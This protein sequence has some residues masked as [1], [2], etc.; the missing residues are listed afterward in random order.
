MDSRTK[1]TKAWP[2]EP[3]K[4]DSSARS[5]I[6]TAAEELFAELGFDAA[7]LRQIAIKARVPVALVSYHFKDKLGLYRAVF[8]AR[9]PSSLEQRKAGL[10][11]AQMESDPQR[12]LEMIIKALIVP[13][14]KLRSAES[15]VHFGTLSA[16]EANDPRAVERGIM[17]A[18]VDP[19]ALASIDLLQKTLPGGNRTD[20]GW[21]F[22][23]IVGTMLFIMADTGRLK[24]LTGG[25]CDP[26]N[27]DATLSHI[28]PLLLDG[29]RGRRTRSA[30]KSA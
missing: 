23:M 9:S 13:M 18:L 22:Q 10:A 4:D 30:A 8:E 7:S 24:R 11:L 1:S 17:Q 27:V 29:V 20:A 25:A 3:A 12:R 15:S 6:L 5:R 26:E 19:V 2:A 28:V 14:L 16:R 21:A